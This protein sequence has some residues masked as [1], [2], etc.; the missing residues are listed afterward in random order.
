MR[1]RFKRQ[2]HI[3]LCAIRSRA[4]VDFSVMTFDDDSVA[5][6]QSKSRA[7]AA[8]GCEEGQRKDVRPGLERDSTAIVRDLNEKKLAVAARA[9]IA[10][11]SRDF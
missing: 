1:R 5:D 4:E 3:K 9:D 6:N 7:G 11:Q 2:P 10:Q 8:L